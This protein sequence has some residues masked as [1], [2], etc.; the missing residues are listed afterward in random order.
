M[1]RYL[2]GLKPVF[3]IKEIVVGTEVKYILYSNTPGKIKLQGEGI[4]DSVNPTVILVME[5]DDDFFSVPL[6]AE[7]VYSGKSIL[8]IKGVDY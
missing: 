2:C 6:V 1:K 8:H 7:D 3:N 5:P 4:I